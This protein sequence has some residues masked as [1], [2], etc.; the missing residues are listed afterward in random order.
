M[1]IKTIHKNTHPII[2][3]LNAAIVERSGE[4]RL[5]WMKSEAWNGLSRVVSLDEG[6][7]SNIESGFIPL[8]LLLL[9]SNFVSMTDMVDK[10]SRVRGEQL[11]DYG[12]S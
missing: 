11:G 1:L 4:K 10:E 5:S 9:D 12:F 3:E 6:A 8:T 2:P 7:Y